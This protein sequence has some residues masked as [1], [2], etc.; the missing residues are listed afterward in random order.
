MQ[1]QPTSDMLFPVR[2]LISELSRDLTLLPGTLILTGTPDGVGFAR[3]PPVYL[4]H[5]DEIVVEIAPLGRLVNR[6]RDAA[7]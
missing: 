4:Q 1:E 5:G 6:V 3:K 7:M 2:A